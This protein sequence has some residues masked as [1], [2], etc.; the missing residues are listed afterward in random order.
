MNRRHAAP[1]KIGEYR[2]RLSVA[3]ERLD[4]VLRPLRD[5]TGPLLDVVATARSTWEEF[6]DDMPAV[7][8]R[9]LPRISESVWRAQQLAQQINALAISYHTLLAKPEPIP[10]GLWLTEVPEEGRVPNRRRRGKGGSA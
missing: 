10:P 4:D 7:L 2:A 6:G 3:L 8:G 9:L 5:A 1:R